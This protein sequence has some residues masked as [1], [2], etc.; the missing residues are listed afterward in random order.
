MFKHSHHLGIQNIAPPLHLLLLDNS[1]IEEPPP[2]DI[3]PS[4]FPIS[5]EI[6]T[7]LSTR[8]NRSKKSKSCR[9]GGG[10]DHGRNRHGGNN[11]GDGGNG[12]SGNSYN[13]GGDNMGLGGDGVGGSNGGLTDNKTGTPTTPG[14]GGGK[15]ASMRKQSDNNNDNGDEPEVAPITINPDESYSPFH[16]ADKSSFNPARLNS[17]QIRKM[18]KLTLAKYQAY[19]KPSAEIIQNIDESSARAKMFTKSE[20]KKLLEQCNSIR[21]LLARKKGLVSAA[22][23]AIALENAKKAEDRMKDKFKNM[24]LARETELAFLVEGQPNSIDAIRLKEYLSS[25]PTSLK[26]GL[27]K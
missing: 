17:R 11:N 26:T 25:K 1:S 19:E 3:G 8:F 12:N 6:P 5:K 16:L 27:P 10:S 23:E 20:H 22:E 13:S 9:G 4:L 2:Y 14:G 18:D 21:T 15:K 7:F 24:A